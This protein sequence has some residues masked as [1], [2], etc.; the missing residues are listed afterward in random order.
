MEKRNVLDILVAISIRLVYAINHYFT[1][2]VI[3]GMEGPEG[4]VGYHSLGGIRLR[5]SLI[6]AWL[7]CCSHPFASLYPLFACHQLPIS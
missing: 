4:I 2:G 6:T 5:L 7:G 1:L 3:G